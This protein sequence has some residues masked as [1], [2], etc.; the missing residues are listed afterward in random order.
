MNKLLV[1]SFFVGLFYSCSTTQP[2]TQIIKETVRDTVFI[3]K[4]AV[5]EGKSY[6]SAVLEDY[7]ITDKYF[8]ARGQDFRQK[9][10][11]MHYTALHNER[12]VQVLTEQTVSS[13]YLVQ[14]YNDNEIH[15]LVGEDERAWHAG[16]SYW[17]GRT[18]IN[19]SSIG[20]EIVNEGYTLLDKKM[21]FFPY[22]EHQFK[23][24]A[25]LAK[26]IVQR[27]GIDPTFVLAHSDIAPQRKEDPG[28]FFPWKRLYEEY[29][30]GAW[31]DDIDKYRF[32]NSYS[33]SRR[34]D[35]AFIREFQGELAKYGYEIQQT[36]KWDEQTRRVVMAFQL[37]FRPENYSGNI[38]RE[39]LAI[40]KA[41]NFKYRQK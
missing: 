33:E 9:F 30:V 5:K 19:D 25:Q 22:P 27:Y 2:V 39:T 37:H 26:N 11:I 21:W 28:A 36:G 35:A 7:K 18:N 6:H 3:E 4:E 10:L 40:I 12:S 20:I 41:L 23:K 24:V 17:M 31:Y 16:A 14:D 1:F 8:P 13:H 15:I 32:W 29:G 34:N 38:D